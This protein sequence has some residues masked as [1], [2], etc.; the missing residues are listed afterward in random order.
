VSRENVE[1]VRRGYAHRQDRGDFL[2]EILAPDYVWDMSHFRGWPEQQ[3]YVGIEEARRFIR[4]WTA[5]FDDWEIDVVA[6]HDAGGDKVVGVLR[7]R[8]RSKATGLPVD[9]LYAQ[10]F[11]L[12]DGK[13]TRMEMY[14][15]PD[16]ALKAV[17]L[18]E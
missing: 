15:D 6:V 3:T 8:G 5:A 10:V 4:D 9:M 11:T 14:A 7:Q 18:E 2:V 13:Q 1:I 17:G 16:E 12:R